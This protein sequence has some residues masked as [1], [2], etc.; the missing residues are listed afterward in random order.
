MSRFLPFVAFLLVGPVAAED[1]ARFRGPTG[2]GVSAAKGL[3]TTWG[4]KE[5]I[6]WKTELPGAGTSSPVIAGEKIYLTCYTGFNVP[7]KRGGSMD[8]LKLHLVRL[9][10]D[11][12]KIDFVKDVTPRL[13]EQAR[14]RD[15]HGY[16]SSTPV[17]EGERVYVFFGKTGVFA[18]DL[19]GKQEWHA[20]VGS[21]L[22]G[23]GTGASP[24]VVG[25]L[26]I[27]NASVESQSLV[28]LNKKTGKEAWRVKGIRDAWNTPILVPVG[29]KT[30]LALASI[31]KV[32]GFDTATGDL[33]WTCAT[34]GRW[35]IV[36]SMVAADG[37]LY[38][39]GGRDG[40]VAV[41]VKAGGRGDVTETHRLWTS[42]VGTNVSSPIVH[43]GHLYWMND[44]NGTA[45]C[46]DVKDGKVV[47]EERFERP[48][49]VYSSP[50]LAD[51]KLYFVGRGGRTY[52]LSATPKLE[53]LAVNDLGERAT[54]NASPAVS[55]D[56]LLI[57]S[58][59]HL[60][61]IGKK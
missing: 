49:Q 35:Y 3:P 45:Y 47:K 54:F 58:D 38:S 24:I 28:A 20:D 21:E 33:L 50:I 4:P 10:R 11:S 39:L 19:D 43:E 44:N 26:V 1:W 52:V 55:G 46:A 23:F 53:R 16:A 34:G 41:A 40:I 14:I 32:Q 2:Q 17:V 15:D 22:N 29:G 57:R 7:G 31:G 18:F 5:N 36:P 25:D 37:V 59:G 13:P 6:V 56:R 60:Y 30:E 12:G 61:C 51:G 48:Q 42:K 9:S 27:V 8:D